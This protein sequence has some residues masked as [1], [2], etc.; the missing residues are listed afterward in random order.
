MRRPCADREG[1][2]V[3]YGRDMT[4]EEQ[5]DPDNPNQRRHLGRVLTMAER[6]QEARID[7][8]KQAQMFMH[9]N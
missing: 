3:T 1:K 8:A 5:L 6:E 7:A 9:P 2:R 4:N